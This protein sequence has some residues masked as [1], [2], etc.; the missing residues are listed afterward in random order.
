MK[1]ENTE[2]TKKLPSIEELTKEREKIFKD[3]K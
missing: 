3:F 2:Q 1:Q